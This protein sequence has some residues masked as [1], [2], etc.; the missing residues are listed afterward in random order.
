MFFTGC[1]EVDVDEEGLG[2]DALEVESQ[3]QVVYANCDNEGISDINSLENILNSGGNG[4]SKQCRT[5]L[6]KVDFQSLVDNFSFSVNFELPKPAEDINPFRDSTFQWQT[7]S[8]WNTSDKTLYVMSGISSVDWDNVEVMGVNA[9]GA[10]TAIN[11]FSLSS[12]SADFSVIAYTTDYSGSMLDND[13]RQISGYFSDFHQILTAL[14]PSTVQIFSDSVTPIT[15]GF[16]TNSVSL[17]NAFAFD[18]AY[19][20]ASTAL[21]DAWARALMEIKSSNKFIGLNIMVTDGF[22]NS[23]KTTDEVTLRNLIN[24]VNAYNLVIACGWAEVNKL[25]NLV[26]SKG[27]V[28]FKYQIDEAVQLAGDIGSALDNIRR[29]NVNEDLSSYSELQVIENGVKKMV[30]SLQ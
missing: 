27:M 8:E 22:E 28:V 24:E 16:I 7:I 4:I 13:I 19:P 26:G 3:L 17:V 23:S 29:L 9:A 5:A 20:R 10:E 11:D 15:T 14:L 21:Y 2:E 1:L 25:K 18:E 30:V 6:G 12:L